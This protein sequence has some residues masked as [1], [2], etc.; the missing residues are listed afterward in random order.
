MSKRPLKPTTPVLPFG[1]TTGRQPHVI[2]PLQ[3]HHTP[4]SDSI[5]TEKEFRTYKLEREVH[6]RGNEI[7]RHKE[8]I[9]VLKNALEEQKDMWLLGLD[10]GEWPSIGQVHQ[11][12]GRIKGA[13]D[14]K[15]PSYTEPINKRKK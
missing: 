15:G 7:V 12:L 5:P 6:H 2:V 14:Y 13:L 3:E 1:P 10:Q 9:R 8:I 11:M 4:A